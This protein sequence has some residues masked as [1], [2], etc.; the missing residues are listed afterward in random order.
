MPFIKR[1]HASLKAT[2]KIHLRFRSSK[3][4]SQP[5][6]RKEFATGL[7]ITTIV[8]IKM[9]TNAPPRSYINQL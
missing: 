7:V 1:L 5:P 3:F 4:S 6:L 9:T 2:S 8:C